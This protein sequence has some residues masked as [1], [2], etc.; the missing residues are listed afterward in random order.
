MRDGILSYN[1]ATYRLGG[2]P[3]ARL[4]AA[5]VV[6][7]DPMTA[8]VYELAPEHL[9]EEL[10]A[11]T[12]VVARRSGSEARGEGSD[13]GKQRMLAVRYMHREGEGGR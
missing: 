1:G 3:L 2:A 10:D 12:I 8:G 13:V 6:V 4:L 5:G 9:I 11:D 7:A